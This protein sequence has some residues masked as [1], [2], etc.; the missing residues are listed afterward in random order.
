M[1]QGSPFFQDEFPKLSAGDGK[2][3]E[4]SKDKDQG[5]QD[6]QYGPGPSLR[7]QSKLRISC[8]P[9]IVSILIYPKFLFNM[10][11]D[12]GFSS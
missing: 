12:R 4:K 8:D 2:L 10:Y 1:G 11:H 6:N 7:P 9:R 5:T 3:E